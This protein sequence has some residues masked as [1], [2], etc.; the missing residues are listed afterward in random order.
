MSEKVPAR[1]EFRV[2]EQE[3]E[4]D[5]EEVLLGVAGVSLVGVIAKEQEAV[6]PPLEPR[7]DQR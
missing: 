7:Q 5:S 6:L 3:P 1:Q 2:V 4:V